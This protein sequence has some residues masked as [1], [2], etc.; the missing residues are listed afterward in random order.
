M[1]LFSLKSVTFHSTK[2]KDI[3]KAIILPLVYYGYETRP[4]RGININYNCWKQELIKVAKP[5]KDEVRVQ[6][7][8]LHNM[9]LRNLD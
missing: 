2:D 7:R 1:L 6:W 9:E 3:H 8:V 5:K 4:L